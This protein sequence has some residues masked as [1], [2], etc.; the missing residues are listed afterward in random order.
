[1]D[2]RDVIKVEAEKEVANSTKGKDLDRYLVN[3]NLNTRMM[4]AWE[5]LSQEEREGY[6]HKEEQDRRRFMEEDEVASRHCFTLTARLSSDTRD[7]DNDDD[8]VDEKEGAKKGGKNED[9]GN[10]D[11]D[12]KGVHMSSSGLESKRG[13]EEGESSDESPS[14]KNKIE[15]EEI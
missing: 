12:E 15:R 4:K 9:N 13:Q 2:V 14:K 11:E 10:G 8:D 6:M 5:D 1:M 3:T 7:N